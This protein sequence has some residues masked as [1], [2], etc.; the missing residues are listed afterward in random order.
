MSSSPLRVVLD[1]NVVR[2]LAYTAESHLEALEE[3]RAHGATLHLADSTVVELIRQLAEG[4]LEWPDWIRCRRALIG[5]LHANDPVLAAG[6]DELLDA[7]ITFRNAPYPTA[8]L[9]SEVRRQERRTRWKAIVKARSVSEIARRRWGRVGGRVRPLSID[10]A[11]AREI[12][13]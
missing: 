9:H 11:S 12:L 5:L 13:D 4:R 2:G 8:E 6:R 10:L 3:A 1:S 7:G